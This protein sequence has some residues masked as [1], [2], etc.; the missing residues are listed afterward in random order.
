MLK[1]QIELLRLK[2][3]TQMIF[4][5][6]LIAL[7]FRKD[8]QKICTMTKIVAKIK[9]KANQPLIQGQNSHQKS[10]QTPPTRPTNQWSILA[11]RTKTQTPSTRKKK[12]T[13]A[14]MQKC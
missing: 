11:K 5:Q 12:E 9:Q 8:K 7:R 3:W 4:Q 10:N 1:P 14:A 13:K 2:T 6:T